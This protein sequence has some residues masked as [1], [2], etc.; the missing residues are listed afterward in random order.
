MGK[1]GSGTGSPIGGGMPSGLGTVD[2]GGSAGDGPLAGEPSGGQH[3]KG[4]M[5]GQFLWRRPPKRRPSNKAARA[6]APRAMR[7]AFA[8]CSLT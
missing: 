4:V 3:G 7:A 1:V 5:M 8:G 2:G 6:P